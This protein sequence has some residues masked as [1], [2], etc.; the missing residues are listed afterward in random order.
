MK[1]IDRRQF[2]ANGVAAAP[3][4]A[5]AGSAGG[6]AAAVTASAASQASGATAGQLLKTGLSEQRLRKIDA[7]MAAAIER[8]DIPGGVVTLLYR[9]GVIAHV[10]VN[11]WQD[12][13]KT[14]P[15]KRDSIFRL[16]SM[17]KPVTAAATL[18]LVEDGKLSLYDPVEKFIPE[19]AN[20]KVLRSISAALDDTVPVKR[21]MR[22]VDLLNFR[23]G[24]CLA[25]LIH[26][27][28]IPTHGIASPQRL[29]PP[30]STR[31]YI[32]NHLLP[33][34][35]APA[36][37]S[38]RCTKR[39]LIARSPRVSCCPKIATNCWRAH[40]RLNFIKRHAMA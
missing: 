10:S 23:S 11:G 26:G 8:G 14:A 4:V 40:V 34:C 16:A 7:A 13:A 1:Q 39:L 35:M 21:P 32:P 29:R 9:H 27:T 28:A 24:W 20:S 6:L 33:A 2:L 19:F 25:P 18:I 17:T 38:W 31:R 15:I 30:I 5:L 3:A 12:Y 36:R 22:V 37:T